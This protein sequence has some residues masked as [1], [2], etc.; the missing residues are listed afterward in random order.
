LEDLIKTK[1][2]AL[3]KPDKDVRVSYF[4]R[5]AFI[6]NKRTLLVLPGLDESINDYKDFIT[7][8]SLTFPQYSILAIDL[9]GQGKTL[10]SEGKID[11]FKIPVENQI[12][13]IREI[14]NSL[15]IESLFIIGLS[16][17]AG[18]ALCAANQIKKIEGLALLAPYVSK[19]KNFSRGF[20]GV[21]YSLLHLNPFYKMISH[22]SL[23]I[24]FQMARER[25]K[26]NPNILWTN[27]K[28]NALA[29]L[30]TGIME[31]STTKEAHRLHNLPKGI[32]ILIG[33]KDVM[34]SIA[35]VEHLFNQI[36][37]ENK[38]I[39]I[40]PD[41]DHRLLVNDYSICIKWLAE[42]IGE[43][44]QIYQSETLK[45]SKTIS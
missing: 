19:F 14:T 39:R 13:I 5:P 9:R 3:I 40:M 8:L 15:P 2:I 7:E 37:L 41:L 16:Y 34:V 21:W 10:A 26:L 18:I 12:T 30:S 20:V 25:N 33:E 29:K 28:L 11:A 31:V 4:W 38:T 22:F 35:A 23:P 27:N 36:E 24:H 6:D 32:H 1:L 42:I 43:N 44:A 45:A 17:G